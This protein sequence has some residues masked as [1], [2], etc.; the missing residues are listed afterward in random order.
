M[1]KADQARKEIMGRSGVMSDCCGTAVLMNKDGND[2]CADCL[3]CCDCLP[4]KKRQGVI[5][6]K[7]FNVLEAI[8]ADDICQVLETERV[9][10]GIACG[11]CPFQNDE[12]LTR[13]LTA[14]E[15]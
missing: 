10:Q 12:V 7:L 5:G 6:E 4:I 13:E 8:S 2:I 3:E 1:T 9:C 15:V 14:L 11:D